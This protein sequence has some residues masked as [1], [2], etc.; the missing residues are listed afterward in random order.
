MEIEKLIARHKSAPLRDFL[1]IMLSNRI[2]RGS[3]EGGMISVKA[4][5]ELAADIE[6][7]LRLAWEAG[8]DS[9]QCGK[10]DYCVSFGKDKFENFLAENS[11]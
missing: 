1:G 11:L 3:S 10:C 9:C 2:D 4:F 8:K 7:L 5:P 6:T